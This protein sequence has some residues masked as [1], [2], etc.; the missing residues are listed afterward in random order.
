[1]KKNKILVIVP[2]NITFSSYYRSTQPHIQLQKQFGD[3][4]DITFNDE[5][6]LEQKEKLLKYNII[7]IHLNENNENVKNI[8]KF[9][10]EN[11]IKI[12]IDT[13]EYCGEN[14]N[15]NFKNLIKDVDY[16]ITTTPQLKKQIEKYNTQVFV[17]PN[18]INPDDKNF[19][20]KKD[21]NEKLR[22]GIFVD[23]HPNTCD[24]NFLNGVVNKLPKDVLEKIKFVLCG[25]DNKHRDY[26]EYE[27]IITDNYKL[28]SAS[29]K[30]FLHTFT[31]DIEYKNVKNEKYKRNW[32]GNIYKHFN[33]YNEID[34]LL[35]PFKT[36]NFNAYKMHLNLIEAAFSDT[37]VISSDVKAYEN[38]LINLIEKNVPQ[39]GTPDYHG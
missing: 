31:P 14:T 28:C 17:I 12:I 34:I 20:S 24:I 21:E 13:D 32:R 16:V 33:Y 6:I 3:M 8:L 9:C 19:Q 18:G 26:Y 22:I 29:Y 10:K 23:N 11:N 2:D 39:A 25:F 15:K 1:M 5:T 38:D 7:H 27:K 35:L 37:A 30:N 4:F 36:N